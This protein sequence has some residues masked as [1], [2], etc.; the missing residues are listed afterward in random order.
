MPPLRERVMKLEIERKLNAAKPLLLKA[1]R[2][3]GADFYIHVVGNREMEAVRASLAARPDFKGREARKIR[4]EEQ[5]NVL[6]FPEPAGFPHPDSAKPVLGEIYLNYDFHGEHPAIPVPPGLRKGS[7][8]ERYAVLGPLLV[9][10]LLHLAGYEHWTNRDTIKMQNREK[11]LWA[12][13]I[14]SSAST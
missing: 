10:G 5:V 7:A 14:S 13:L 4:A 6:A 9:H 11:K 2:K 3:P 1:I 8:A 12:A